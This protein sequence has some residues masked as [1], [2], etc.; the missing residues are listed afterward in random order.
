MVCKAYRRSGSGLRHGVQ[1][2]PGFRPPWKKPLAFFIVY[3]KGNPH[4]LIFRLLYRTPQAQ[5]CKRFVIIRL[6][7]QIPLRRHLIRKC[8]ISS[9]HFRFCRMNDKRFSLAYSPVSQGIAGPAFQPNCLYGPA[10]TAISIAFVN[11]Y[12]GR[13]SGQIHIDLL[14]GSHPIP[15]IGAARLYIRHEKR[16][17]TACESLKKFPYG[18][19]VTDKRPFYLLFLHGADQLPASCLCYQLRCVGIA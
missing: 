18:F 13:I 8:D 5:S 11:M 12:P 2:I 6:F 7:Y 17:L 9:V 16:A 3:I 4:R 15:Q 1:R 19:P 10:L 14:S